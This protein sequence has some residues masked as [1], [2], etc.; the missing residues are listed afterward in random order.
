M[1]VTPI[2][3]QCAV[4]LDRRAHA[5]IGIS[6]FNSY[7]SVERIRALLAWGLGRFDALHVFVPDVPA[8]YTLEASGYSRQEAQ[9]K[10][11]R[12]ANYL[13]NKIRRAFEAVGVCGARADEMV[14]DWARLS[15]MPAYSD[16]LEEC[17]ALYRSDS[18]FRE[19]CLQSA[20]WVLQRRA[21]RNGVSTEALR[22]GAKYF[23]T[24][25]PLF[26]DSAGILKQPASV[27]C[28]HQC[29]RFVHELL[30]G[31]HGLPISQNQ[32]F[33]IVRSRTED[34]PRA[35]AAS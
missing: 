7:F 13:G 31:Q 24:E 35:T 17:R 1:I 9:R 20:K 30:L 4:V 5:L 12:Q 16:R 15:D 34:G 26:V 3:K 8:A 27:F 32:G 10:A 21:G 2:T 22:L 25:I 6:P 28:Y 18:A 33:V 29:P 23:L 19:G 14:L 11:R